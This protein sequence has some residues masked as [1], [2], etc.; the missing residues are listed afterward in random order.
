MTG[1]GVPRF[2]LGVGPNQMAREF[3]RDIEEGF[4]GTDV[5]AGVLKSKV[6]IAAL[7]TDTENV[8]LVLTGRQLAPEA[9]E[10]LL[11]VLLLSNV[12]IN[13][14]Y[15]LAGLVLLTLIGAGV[16]LFVSIRRDQPLYDPALLFVHVIQA[17]GH[18]VAE[19]GRRVDR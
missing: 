12:E 17:E 11:P 10:W 7:G 19:P 2:L 4:R 16:N 1:G 13:A 5:K 8:F 6:L 9:W 14:F 18:L 3:V 15:F